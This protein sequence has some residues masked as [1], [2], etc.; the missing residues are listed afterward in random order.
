MPQSPF[1]IK[2]NV[3][4]FIS[5]YFILPFVHAKIADSFFQSSHPRSTSSADP[6]GSIFKTDP[7][8]TFFS[9]S[10]H[11]HPSPIL[12]Q[13]LSGVLYSPWTDLIAFPLPLLCSDTH[14]MLLS[15][16]VTGK[17]TC[18]VVDSEVYTTCHQPTNTSHY[19][20]TVMG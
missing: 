20:L 6:V 11:K 7:E 4:L 14:E 17:A 16:P 13:L 1:W 19:I 15:S 2:E 10:H 18:L 8:P 9:P 12:S 5:L 3:I